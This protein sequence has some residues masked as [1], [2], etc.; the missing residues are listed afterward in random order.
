M[1][2]IALEI[3]HE[4]KT[5]DEESARHFALAVR[6]LLRLAKARQNK[7]PRVP[8]SQRIVTDAAIG[9]WPAGRDV[10]QHIAALRE[11]WGQ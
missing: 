7:L 1:N 2:A 3:D 6:A 8:F 10:D 5:L 9:T 11:E 4:L